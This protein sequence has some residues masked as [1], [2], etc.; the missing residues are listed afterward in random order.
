MGGVQY[1][2]GY[3]SL[4][5]EHHGG[6]IMIHVGDNMSTVGDVQYH[7]VGTQITK[8]FPL[9]ILNTLRSTDDIPHVHHDISPQ[10]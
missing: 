1:R 8:D 4:K 5:F 9:T 6:D 10:Y 7:G 2:G 3:H